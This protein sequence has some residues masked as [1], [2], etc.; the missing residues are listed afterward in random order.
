MQL[1]LDRLHKHFLG[2]DVKE[3]RCT[4]KTTAVIYQ[5]IGFAQVLSDTNI[6]ILCAMQDKEHIVNSLFEQLNLKNYYHRGSYS[7]KCIYNNND[8]YVMTLN[9]YLNEHYMQLHHQHKKHLLLWDY[10]IETSV[11]NQPESM[12]EIIN[13]IKGGIVGAA[14]HEVYKVFGNMNVEIIN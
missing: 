9:E 12:Y 6:F 8:V 4:G 13:R 7:F 1:N 10:R 14:A 5:A 11:N 2:E 3:N